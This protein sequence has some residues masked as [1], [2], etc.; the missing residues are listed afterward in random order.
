MMDTSMKEST[1]IRYNKVWK[2]KQEQV[3][4]E[5]INEGHPKVILSGLEIVRY[6]EKS[7]VKK[8]YVRYR[9]VRR[10]NKNKSNR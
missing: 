1:N 9:K 8:E 10:R 6:Q 4:K 7:I 5:Q 3:K 2:R